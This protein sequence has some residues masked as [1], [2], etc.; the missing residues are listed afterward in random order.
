MPDIQQG[1]ETAPLA[2][3]LTGGELAARGEIVRP[4]I[5]SYQQLQELEDGY[6]SSLKCRW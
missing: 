4:L 2:C 3:L 1:E 5:A 6:A